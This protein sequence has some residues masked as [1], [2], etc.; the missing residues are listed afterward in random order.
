MKPAIASVLAVLLCAG[1]GFA[2][3]LDIKEYEVIN[4]LPEPGARELKVEDVKM[5]TLTIGTNIGLLVRYRL[6]NTS[7]N[8]SY[9]NKCTYEFIDRDGFSF[10]SGQMKAQHKSVVY[11]HMDADDYIQGKHDAILQY[12]ITDPGEDYYVQ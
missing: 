6:R 4:M 2:Q 3:V 7:K 1:M 5:R 10:G 8:N 12:R 11:I 9:Y